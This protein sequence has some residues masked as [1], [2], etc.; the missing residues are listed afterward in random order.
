MF[1]C[2]A[3][4]QSSIF[5][6]LAMPPA[7]TQPNSSFPLLAM[8]HRLKTRPKE[9]VFSRAETKKTS[10]RRGGRRAL[11]VP[12]HGGRVPTGA[13]PGHPARGG[14][15]AGAGRRWGG[16]SAPPP[17][18][19]LERAPAQHARA[20]R[21]ASLAP[22][23]PVFCFSELFPSTPHFLCGIVLGKS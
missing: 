20:L 7:F 23:Q 14:P 8:L 9:L 16:R 10:L 18:S 12:S 15:L 2:E 3:H 22:S 21:R 4:L 11:H 1:L 19:S 6:L 17:P 5:L 13:H